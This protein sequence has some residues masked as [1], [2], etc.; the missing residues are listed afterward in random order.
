[1]VGGLSGCT[2]GDDEGTNTNGGETDTEEG[3]ESTDLSGGYDF[4]ACDYE[5]NDEKI[6][7]PLDDSQY[8]DPTGDDPHL[9]EDDGI[10]VGIGYQAD[11]EDDE[12]EA[13]ER[14][15]G[16][17]AIHSEGS[18]SYSTPRDAP[19]DNCDVAKLSNREY[20]E[21]IVPFPIDEP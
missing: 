16:V 12:R 11:I 5:L 3:S 15:F 21:Y 14:I 9:P 7:A 6:N 8:N 2:R 17:D 19:I 10:N 13:L 1:M 4:S 20:I 18:Q